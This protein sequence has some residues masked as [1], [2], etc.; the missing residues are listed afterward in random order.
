MSVVRQ[1]L[2][3]DAPPEDVWRVVSNPRNLPKWNRYVRSVDGV[4]NGELKPGDRYSTTLGVMGVTF[5][6][7]AKVEEVDAPRFARVS[8][9]GPLDAVVR[10]WVRPIGSNRS[11]LEHEVDYRMRGGPVGDII[12]KG[13]Q[14]AG[15]PTLLKR[16]IR[17]QK[18][19]VEVG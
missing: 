6:I 16:G 15:A 4:P 3:V 13:L 2:V 1:W 5:H 8:L 11:R 7:D 10:T 18:R 9:S 12:A 19:Q 17:A 14:L